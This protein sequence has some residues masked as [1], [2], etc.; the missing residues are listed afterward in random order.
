LSQVS[1]QQVFYLIGRKDKGISKPSDLKGKTIGVT[2][3]GAGEF[4]LGKFLA[5]NNIK[6][7]DIKIIDLPPAEMIGQLE[8]GK[9]DAVVIFDPHAYNLIKKLGN[10]VVSWS[11]QGDQK[12]FA[13]LYSTNPFIQTH[14]ETIE[15]Y[16]QA[17]SQAEKFTQDHPKEAQNLIGLYM[18][19]DS[20]YVNHM[21]QAIRFQL[22]LDQTLLLALEEQAAWAME[23]KLATAK[24]IPNYLDHIYFP[25]LEKAKPQAINIIH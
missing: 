23:N 19:Y 5:F 10:E 25:A 7:G 1:Q 22:S 9:I 8:N 6:L 13:L 11:V 16:L 15:R 24:Q 14:P 17:L 3:K 20:N 18:H 21:W 2:R 12:T 4:F